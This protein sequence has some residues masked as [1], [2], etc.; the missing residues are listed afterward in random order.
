M[1]LRLRHQ[2]EVPEGRGRLPGVRSKLP[3]TRKHDYANDNCMNVPLLDLKA[4]YS[5][6]RDEVRAA[7]DQVC[8]SQHF[9][10]GPRVQQLEGEIA[11]YSG[12]GFGIGMSS[13]TDALLAALMA[14]DIGAGDEVITTPFTFFAT[15]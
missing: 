5:V 1:G 10:L 12:A 8:E 13:G 6:I 14:L 4:Q 11:A 2:A 15:G 9:I 7:I 3:E